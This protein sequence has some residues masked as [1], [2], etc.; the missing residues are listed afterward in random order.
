MNYV[1]MFVMVLLIYAVFKGFTRGFIMQLAVLAALAVGLY[2]AIK[3]SD[4]TAAH[5]EEHIHVSAESLYL[6]SL[7]VTFILVFLAVNLVG[8]GVEKIAEA[9]ELSLLNRLL[10]VVFSVLKTLLIVGVLLLFMDRLDNRVRFVPEKTREQSLFYKPLTS[11]AGAIFHQ[12]KLT[13]DKD[14]Q[15][16][17]MV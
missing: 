9:V 14:H 17:Q 5:L 15:D 11:L 8:R 1:D 4:F 3:G 13:S 7:A 6:I 16:Q 2:A 10:G 12:L